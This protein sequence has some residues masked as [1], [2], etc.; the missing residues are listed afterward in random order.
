MIVIIDFGSQ[1]THQIGRRLEE[2]GVNCRIADPDMAMATISNYP[3]K[4]II[5]SG[6]PASVNQKNAPRMD[7]K[8]LSL[9]I[10]IFGICYGWQLM[11]YLLGGK[12]EGSSA[13]YG[14]QTLSFTQ[15][16]FELK[17]VST[18]VIMSHGDTVTALPKD[19]YSFAST[20]QV[21]YAAAADRTKRLWGLQFH[22]EVEHTE[23]GRDI[24]EYFA[25]NICK[26]E[27]TKFKLNPLE[28]I[29]TIRKTV[30]GE[31]VICAVS[32]GVDSTVAAHLIEKAV[33][34]QLYPVYVKSGLMRPKTE[35]IVQNI[36]G[37]K[38][39]SNLII[40]DAR[41]QFIKAIQD[42]EDPEKKRKTIGNLYVRLFEKE[43]QKLSNVGYLAQGTIYSDVIESKGSTHASRI[44]SHH[45]VG[46]LPKEMPFKLLEPLRHLY[47]DQVRELGRLI[48]L[49]EALIGQHP[50]PGPGYAVR[51]RGRVTEERL[52][53]IQQ[54]DIIV[55]EEIEKAGWR[56]RLFQCFR[57]MNGAFRS[58]V[59]GDARLFAEVV[60][61]RACTSRDVM[62]SEWARLPV[63]LLEVIS[64]RIVNEVPYI[65][66]V[67]YDI[68]SKPPATIEWE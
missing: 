15:D 37:E 48:G 59:T 44:K 41:D 64:N 14:P 32:G 12:I 8:I 21:R 55:M 23:K 30:R 39:H 28:I 18:S 50:F 6:G 38:A 58:A 27:I 34:N 22:P 16:L 17:K 31:S 13:E 61:L 57:W 20:P 10:P 5:L 65:S 49:P 36:F 4:G 45:N 56:D 7:P 2:I 66:R 40:V 43:A 11:A 9:P 25:K 19:F 51:I 26:M 1:T 46:G 33:G 47:K 24:L 63:S 35:E 42:I 52:S 54:A 68:T 29:D 62:T 60:A 53:Q 3:T 67:V